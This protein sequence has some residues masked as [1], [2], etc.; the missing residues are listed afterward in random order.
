MHGRTPKKRVAVQAREQQILEAAR[1]VFFKKGFAMATTAEI[2][3]RA[4]IAEGTIYNY[5]PTKRELFISVIKDIVV[6][7]PLLDIIG[8]MNGEDIVANFRSLLMDR[9]EL[10]ETRPIGRMP[11]LM[12]EVLRDPELKAL[13]LERFLQP[14]LDQFGTVYRF[15]EASGRFRTLEPDVV[16]RVMAGLVLGFILLNI[17]ESGASP[18]DRFSREKIAAEMT[19][20]I[21]Y[22]LLAQ[23]ERGDS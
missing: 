1:D 4:G 12:G 22:G 14:F 21:C 13:W 8:K 15:M 16:V 18:L 19:R 3:G 7:P 10:I 2:A 9:L 23:E 20:F 6:T 11:A 17:F 5:F